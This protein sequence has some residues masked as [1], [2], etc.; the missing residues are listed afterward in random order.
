MRWRS[1]KSPGF[2]PEMSAKKYT[3]SSLFWPGSSTKVRRHDESAST[4]RSET[5]LAKP[6]SGGTYDVIT[7]NSRKGTAIGNHETS[8]IGLGLFRLVGICDLFWRAGR[9]KLRTRPAVG[10]GFCRLLCTD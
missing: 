2:R 7:G 10:R 4:Q 1:E 3:G 8:D 5:N 6:E 9:A